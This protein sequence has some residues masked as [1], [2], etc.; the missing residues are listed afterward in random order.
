MGGFDK[1]KK[2]MVGLVFLTKSIKDSRDQER[3]T[4]VGLND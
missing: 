1:K 2:D 4:M 3:D